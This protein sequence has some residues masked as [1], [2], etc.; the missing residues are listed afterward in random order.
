[1]AHEEMKIPPMREPNGASPPFGGPGRPEGGPGAGGP[2][3]M[4]PVVLPEKDWDNITLDWAQYEGQWKK[5][6]DESHYELRFVYYAT[7]LKSKQ[8]QYM[9]IYVPAQYL[10]ADSSINEAGTCNGYTARTAPIVMYN[11]CGGWMSSTPG[12]VNMDYIKEGF[13]H[14]NVGARSRDQGANGKAPAPCVDQKAAVRML[15]LH[16]LKIPG[17][18]EKIISCGGS[19]GGQMSSILGA[20]G[21]MEA[22]YPWLYEIGA[23]GIEK[24][25]DG[26]YVSTIRDDIY[27]SQCFCPI[28]DINNAEMAYAWMRYDDPK[29]GFSGFGIQG[30]QVLSP[31]KQELQKDLAQEYCAYLNSLE[32]MNEDGVLLKFDQNAD[33]S[34]NPRSGSYYDQIL[35]NVSDAL[36]K[37]VGAVVQKDGS[38][39]YSVSRGPDG[40]EAFYYPSLDAYLATKGD[41]N[42]WLKKEGGVFTVTDFPAFIRNTDLPRGKDCPGFDTFHCT[43][44]NN[45]FGKPEESGVH[46]SASTAKILAAHQ[47]K[48]KTLPGYDE[49]DVDAYIQQGQRED[50]VRQTY[51]MNATHIMLNMAAG[52]EDATPARHWRTRN[53]T[54]DEHTSFTIAYNLCMAAKKA[55]STVDYALVWNAG[56]GDVDGD[57]TGTFQEWVHKI[58]K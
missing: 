29:I 17:D 37:W 12:D 56:H 5:S 32:L 7:N 40:E 28:A 3:G 57:G 21:N 26:K 16:D 49:C 11:N 35:K 19:G 22:Y 36:N 39:R 45:A 54:A 47:A 8:H 4:K 53:G 9:N 34:Y 55:G 50:I 38:I 51:L 31:F 10:N 33:G 52:K 18:K 42:E 14:V 43:A 44:E 58:C 24:A 25:A 46:F 15:R 13:V 27:G 2:P 41:L 6:E 30:E 23:A 20:T 48:Y 1:M